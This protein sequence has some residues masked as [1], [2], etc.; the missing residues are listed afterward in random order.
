LWSILLFIS[1]QIR[2]TGRPS[3]GLFRQQQALLRTLLSPSSLM[4]ESTKLWWYWRRKNNK[5]LTRS[6]VQLFLATSCTVSFIVAGIASSFVVTSSDLEVLVQSPFCG[7]VNHSAPAEVGLSYVIAVSAVSDPY[8]QECYR[9]QTTLPARCKAYVHSRVDFTTEKAACPFD[10]KFCGAS[11]LG[12][13]SAIALD[14][15]LVDINAAFGFNLPEKD[16]VKYRRRTTCA[17]LP[18]EG[19]TTIVDA[20]NFPDILQG[21]PDIPGEQFLIAHY[22]NRPDLGEWSNTTAF[23]SL[24]RGNYSA[25]YTTL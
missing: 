25:K 4:A 19:R 7:I 16:R 8:A 24:L 9:N 6:L 1:H 10:V 13:S 20:R 12:N 2:A 3:D 11:T 17:I 14:S 23:Y 22:G 5:V 18:L 21:G 15:G